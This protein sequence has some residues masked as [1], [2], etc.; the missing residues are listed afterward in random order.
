M[1]SK[2]EI[3]R[4]DIIPMA[5]YA[6]ERKERRRALVEAK[7]NR[8]LEVGGGPPEPRPKLKAPSAVATISA[9]DLSSPSP[10]YSRRPTATVPD[11][12]APKPATNAGAHPN[13]FLN[14][15]SQDSF[16]A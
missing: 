9:S 16:S 5:D 11:A 1:E 3:T 6:R 14:G 15:A 13:P 10:E 4:A 8:R 12:P 2:H 7:K